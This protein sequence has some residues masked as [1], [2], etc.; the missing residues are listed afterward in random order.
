MNRLIKRKVV[1]AVCILAV[2]LTCC[3]VPATVS[4]ATVLSQDFQ[5]VEIGAF[6]AEPYLLS[7]QSDIKGTVQEDP[8]NKNNRAFFIDTSAALSSQPMGID[9]PVVQDME[10][11]AQTVEADLYF[12]NAFGTNDRFYNGIFTNACTILTGA[13]RN[14]T[15]FFFYD[16][17][18]PNIYSGDGR[19]IYRSFPIKRWFKMR[20]VFHK[21]TLTYD[22]YMV[23][24]GETI[25]LLK[26][27]PMPEKD[28]WAALYDVYSIKKARFT[29][30]QGTTP[31]KGM[32]ID[33]IAMYNTEILSQV[34]G[35]AQEISI[36]PN[37]V[38][39]KL[40]K[41]YGLLS[42]LSIITPS[43]TD[44][45]LE[46]NITRGEFTAATA[47]LMNIDTDQP[48]GTRYSDVPADHQYAGAIAAAADYGLVSK[49][50]DIFRPDD[51]ITNIEA[52]IMLLRVGDYENRAQAM[53]GYPTGYIRL[54]RDMGIMGNVSDVNEKITRED[55]IQMLADTLDMNVQTQGVV[56]GGVSSAIDKDTTVMNRFHD[57]WAGSGIL[58]A[59]EAA[60]FFSE[61]ANR[62]TVIID[63]NTILNAYAGI[64][65]LIGQKVEYFYNGD[66][67]TIIY[68]APY[69]SVNDVIEIDGDD[70]NSVSPTKVE[71]YE[72]DKLKTASFAKDV[73]VLYNGLPADPQVLNSLKDANRVT[74]ISNNGSSSYN[75]FLITKTM[76][77]FVVGDKNASEMIISDKNSG[78]LLNLKDKESVSFYLNGSA[79]AINAVATG[80]VVSVGTELMSQ[81]SELM[82][83]NHYVIYISTKLV[84]GKVIS[85]SDNEVQIADDVYKFSLD[86]E[87]KA[88]GGVLFIN[89]VEIRPGEDKV[90]LLDAFGKIAGVK[91][92]NRKL[93]GYGVILGIEQGQGIGRDV[94]VKMFLASGKEQVFTCGEYLEID[95]VKMKS[96]KAISV[97]TPYIT[98]EVVLYDTNM[99]GDLTMIDTPVD[100]SKEVPYIPYAVGEFAMN[101]FQDEHFSAYSEAF[102]PSHTFNNSTVVFKGSVGYPESFWIDA[103]I[104]LQ[105]VRYITGAKMKIYDSSSAGIAGVCLVLVPGGA[106][107]EVGPGEDMLSQSLGVVKSITEGVDADGNTISRLKVLQNGSDINLTITDDTI[108]CAG[109]GA[110]GQWAALHVKGEVNGVPTYP[111]RLE[112]LSLKQGDVIQYSLKNGNLNYIH[113]V[114]NSDIPF[115]AIADYMS[116]SGAT[117]GRFIATMGIAKGIVTNNTGTFVSL[118]RE[119]CGLVRAFNISSGVNVLIID[120]EKDR[121]YAGSKSDVVPGTKVLI[122]VDAK[123]VCSDIVVL[124]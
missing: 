79:A 2:L 19:I 3:V 51:M 75:V 52:I 107:Q 113:V 12:A 70:L 61:K 67:E 46:E 117:E 123:L 37:V 82:A 18:G 87:V 50:S 6:P 36:P 105:D 47:R 71:Y 84:N 98:S 63:E 86:A 81:G 64:G 33:N 56:D 30:I 88:E 110:G 32:Y 29:Y 91:E 76:K 112:P 17:R 23:D 27:E 95:K 35:A 66:T 120:K 14:D 44:L 106:G 24:R 11:E 57:V 122:K 38:G 118:D 94:S 78:L 34:E 10:T 60:S 7:A 100:K 80:S 43:E 72:D 1:S 53:G 5:K 48:S 39:T 83:A 90:F 108:V 9:T 124:K 103:P 115:D 40:E 65:A 16:F 116:S 96:E 111:T 121:I 68:A 59:T 45:N 42:S 28:N 74:L 58:K 97:L 93:G 104:S 92:D 114:N 102:A 119:F 73:T 21:E 41:G 99:Y 15:Q 31:S 4:A 22:V 69:K 85:I 20:V 8:E 109:S 25:E 101:Y 26:S 13:S 62:G 89:G 49:E 54:A 55:M 77:T